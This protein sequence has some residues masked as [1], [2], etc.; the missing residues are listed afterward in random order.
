VSSTEQIKS[1]I[2]LV[3]FLR[4]QGLV[5]KRAG[6][7]FKAR[8]PFHE[9]KTPSFM[10]S[11]EK[12]VWHCFGCSMGGD[13]FTFIQEHEGLDFAEALKLL[14]DRAGVQLERSDPRLEGQKTRL[15]TAVEAATD[16]FQR[17]LAKSEST[18]A[19]VHERGIPSSMVAQFQ[20][21]YAPDTWDALTADLL[22][23]G[24][25]LH[26]LMEAGLTISRDASRT[27]PETRAS[28]AGYDRFRHRLMFPIHDAM[29]RVV[30]FTGRILEKGT[31]SGRDPAKYV[32]T[33][34]TPA[35][36]KSE[37]LYGLAF[38]KKAIRQEG[39]VVLVEGNTDVIASHAAGI[40][41][42]VATSGTALTIKQLTLLKRSTQRLHIAFDADAAG[43]GAAARGIDAALDAGFDVR[44]IATPRDEAGELLGK[45]PDACITADVEMW[46]YAIAN[47]VPILDDL[48]S[49]LQRSH[50]LR[51]PSGQRDAGQVFIARL[52]HVVDPIER[53]AWLRRGAEMI[54][55]PEQSIRDA[56]QRSTPA[57]QGHRH[58]ELS[59]RE[60][61]SKSRHFSPIERYG[62]RI[63][64][65]LLRFP[66]QISEME[67]GFSVDNFSTER[68]RTLYNSLI[69]RYTESN[70][71]GASVDVSDFSSRLELLVDRVYG[72]FDAAQATEELRR[73]RALLRRAVITSHLQQISS[74][75]KILERE[76]SPSVQKELLEL[77]HSVQDLTN[78]LA[79]L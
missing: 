45:D 13:L 58:S 65:L 57:A 42:T 76:D 25:G 31:C 62:N 59:E 56:L 1:K 60:H 71:S 14:A 78:E 17:E 41:N 16:F 32:N 20:L 9:E 5:L 6:A 28:D 77:G 27:T 19:Y 7:S 48:L 39:Y 15:L 53:A 74:R 51:E 23:R 79:T 2:D 10:V 29:G 72:E 43:T 47:P 55:V 49:I 75:L 24:F 8:C 44:V 61:P 69:R 18:Q 36:K 52:A 3:E 73:C 66:E 50:D 40:A 70:G 34:E 11:P 22:K 30:G 37:I 46:R 35:Y 26:D 33:P 21:G 54:G 12:Q 64:A 67:D 4:E 63:L 68:Q 38:A